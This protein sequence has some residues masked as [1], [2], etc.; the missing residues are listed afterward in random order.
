MRRGL[1]NVPP[2]KTIS[3]EPVAVEL[4][5]PILA[6]KSKEPKPSSVPDVA[7]VVGTEPAAMVKVVPLVTSK[8]KDTTSP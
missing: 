7:V 5:A 8:F 4:L 2:V 1:T 3:N 6:T